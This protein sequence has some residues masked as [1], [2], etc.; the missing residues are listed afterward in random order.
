MATGI[1]TR[2]PNVVWHAALDLTMHLVAVVQAQHTLSI[3]YVHAVPEL[4]LYA[5]LDVGPELGQGEGRVKVHVVRVVHTVLVALEI[6]EPSVL[7]PTRLALLLRLK[8]EEIRV[9]RWYY[10]YEGCFCV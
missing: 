6:R 5:G 10:V 8:L 1:L 3:L 4:V 9:V 7:R 2:I